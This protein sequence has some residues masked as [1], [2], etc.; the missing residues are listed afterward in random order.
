MIF[1][2]DR[3]CGV[4]GDVEDK[5]EFVVG[6]A[7]FDVAVLDSTDEARHVGTGAKFFG[8]F[9]DEGSF[10]PLAGFDVAAG[11]ERP[12]LGALTDEEKLTVAADDGPGDDLGGRG[13]HACPSCRSLPLGL[14]V[15]AISEL[16]AE[17]VAAGVAQLLPEAAPVQSVR[18]LRRGRNHVSWVLKPPRGRLVGKVLVGRPRDGFMERLTEHRRVWQHG[19]P[20]PPVLAFTDSCPAVG[21]QPLMVFEYL[22]GTDAEEALR[23]MDAATAL[24]VMRGTGAALARLHQVPV[25]SFGDPVAGIGVGPASWSEV[26]AGRG[27]WLRNPI[28]LS[29]MLRCP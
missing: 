12:G 4:D 28:R 21:G 15:V 10:H 3:L 14:R 27:A 6:H 2:A 29:T 23:V 8:E 24:A 5:V 9:A 1:L 11:Q 18:A 7:V 20:V 22:P 17:D 19:V 26:V 16:T 13:A 25:V